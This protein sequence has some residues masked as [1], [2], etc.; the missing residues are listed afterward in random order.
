MASVLLVARVVGTNVV[1]C[2]SDV[3][4]GLELLYAEVPAHDGE[5]RLQKGLGGRALVVGGAPA[6]NVRGSPSEVGGLKLHVGMGQARG[7]NGA[8]TV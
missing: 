2:D 1:I 3:C 4:E 7:G 8:I 5:L 6:G